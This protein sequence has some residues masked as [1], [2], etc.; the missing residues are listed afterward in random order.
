MVKFFGIAV[1]AK[2]W[3]CLLVVSLYLCW[4]WLEILPLNKTQWW[5][6]FSKG[7]WLFS[8]TMHHNQL[9]IIVFRGS[10]TMLY[11]LSADRLPLLWASEV[12]FQGDRLASSP[13]FPL[14]LRTLMSSLIP[15]ALGFPLGQWYCKY[16]VLIM[17]GMKSVPFVA[18]RVV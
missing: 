5:I 16:S 8:I 7:T 9:Y 10:P 1:D 3:K 18:A 15:F 6:F 2:Y 17:A 11:V 13:V 4:F 14:Q 12:P